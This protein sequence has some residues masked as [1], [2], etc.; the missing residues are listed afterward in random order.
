MGGTGVEAGGSVSPHPIPRVHGEEASDASRGVGAAA[1]QR[2]PGVS[3]HLT[4]T[5]EAGALSTAS[6]FQVRL[7]VF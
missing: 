1:V 4:D 7:L 5:A 6:L 3:R 2:T